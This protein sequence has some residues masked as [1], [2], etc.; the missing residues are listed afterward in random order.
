MRSMSGPV[1]TCGAGDLQLG[2]VLLRHVGSADQ[3]REGCGNQCDAC[4]SAV[5]VLLCGRHRVVISIVG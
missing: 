2:R 3:W 4:P 1:T 5:S